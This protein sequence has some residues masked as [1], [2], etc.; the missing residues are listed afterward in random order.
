LEK[1]RQDQLFLGQLLLIL[2][3][4]GLFYWLDW[5]TASLRDLVHGVDT[6]IL[7]A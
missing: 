2:G 1:D 5:E 6:A 4:C 3:L 7:T